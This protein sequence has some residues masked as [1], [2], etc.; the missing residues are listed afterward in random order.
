MNQHDYPPRFAEDLLNERLRTYLV[1]RHEAHRGEGLPMRTNSIKQRVFDSFGRVL[2][3]SVLV[4][5]LTTWK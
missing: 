5:L 1:W 3:Y 2:H 4:R